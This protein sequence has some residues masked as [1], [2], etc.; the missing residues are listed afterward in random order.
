MH[1]RIRKLRRDKNLTQKEL[2]AI[3]GIEQ[4]NISAYESGKLKPS[5]KTLEKFAFALGVS[6]DTLNREEPEVG[7]LA[8][9]D[10]ELLLLF[11]D[12]A[13]LPADERSKLKWMLNLA[14]RQL[15]IQDVMRAS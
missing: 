8:S 4:K 3:I 14:I 15:R 11:Q 12:L 13:S 7:V 10:P 1:E 2:G 9:S 5:Q 6:V